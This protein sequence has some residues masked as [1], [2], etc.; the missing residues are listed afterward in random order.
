MS[1]MKSLETLDPNNLQQACSLV[2]NLP[3]KNSNGSRIF[4]YNVGKG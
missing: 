4:F 3:A 1:S 2:N